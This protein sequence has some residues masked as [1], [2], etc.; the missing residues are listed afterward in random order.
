MRLTVCSKPI[1]KDPAFELIKPPIVKEPKPKNMD[2]PVR[3]DSAKRAKETIFDI[4]RLNDFTHFI[5]WTLNKEKIDRYD[6]AAVKKKLKRFLN[7]MQQRYRLKY[8]IVPEYHKDGAIHMHGL[9]SG[10]IKLVDSSKKDEHG[11]T[12]YNMPQ[13]T[14][15][16]SGVTCIEKKEHLAEY[17]TKY[18]SKDFK[19]IFGSF[20]YAGGKGLIRHP[21]VTL[22]DTD[23]FQ[24][25]AKEY[26]VPKANLGYKYLS[27]DGVS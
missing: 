23:Y 22:Y 19:K 24:V 21:P 18:I 5:T 14:L 2:N 7:N 10:N 1:F 27:V 8:L 3:N 20:Y 16:F 11:R 6:P 12:I 17:I 13:W 26:S 4:A 9:I 25:N 15:G